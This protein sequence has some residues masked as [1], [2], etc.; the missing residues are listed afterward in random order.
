[1][2]RT[3]HLLAAV[4]L[5]LGLA[6]GARA[7][8]DDDKPPMG[9]KE[10][11]PKDKTFV[12]WVPEK[13][14][15]QVEKDRTETYGK[16]KV[17]VD[18]FVFDTDSA[19][20]FVQEAIF[21]STGAEKIKESMAASFKTGIT[22][23]T[24]GKLTKE[25]DVTVGTAKGKE[26]RMENKD[27]ALRARVL[28]TETRVFM[29]QVSGKKAAIDGDAGTIFLE[30][31]HF[32]IKTAATS[33]VPKILGSGTDP[34][35]KELAPEGGVL[36]GLEV[37]LVKSGKRDIVKSIKPLYLVDGKEA[38]GERHGTR[39]DK[40]VTFKAKEGYAVG[41]FSAKYGGGFD[42]VSV[43]FMKIGGDKLD[44]KDSYESEYVG[45]DEKK[46]PTKV[47]SEGQVVVGIVGK[48]ND[49][50]LTA[51]GLV[52]KGQEKYAPKKKK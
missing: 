34:E 18:S 6:C 33:A 11:M 12:I 25:S 39:A 23:N 21:P 5:A 16:T 48:T 31:G 27:T 40:T 37:G 46:A 20:Y 38:P 45:T 8:K 13:I 43:T 41:G 9:W 35:F 14:K 29:I 1:M 7:Q 50:D 3:V 47:A 52:F 2:H 19:I 49:K 17:K 24:N 28:T 51:F 10:Y 26:Y 42:G 44:P 4:A 36:I 32:N 30:S 15:S 22:A